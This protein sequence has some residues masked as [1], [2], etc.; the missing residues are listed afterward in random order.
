MCGCIGLGGDC[1]RLGDGCA[2]AGCVAVQ[3]WDG[4]GLGVWQCRAGGV[5]VHG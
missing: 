5:T 3:G 1:A 4:A 2:W